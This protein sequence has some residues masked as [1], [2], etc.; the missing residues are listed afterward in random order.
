MGVVESGRLTRRWRLS[1]SGVSDTGVTE[2]DPLDGRGNAAALSPGYEEWR[3]IVDSLASQVVLLDDTGKIV[4]VN[5]AWRRSGRGAGGGSDCVG[6]NYIDVCEASGEPPAL[7][8]AAGLKQLASGESDR[9][10]LVYPCRRP[11]GLEWVLMRAVPYSG[12]HRGWIVITHQ[13][14][15]EARLDHQRVLSQG[16]ALDQLDAA[17]HTTDLARK[18]LTWNAAAERLYGWTADEALGRLTDEL[19][20]SPVD[21]DPEIRSAISSGRWHGELLLGRKDGSSFPAL[22]RTSISDSDDEPGSITCVVIDISERVQYQ[23]ELK[24]ARDHL[25]AVTDS[26]GEGMFTLDLDG[27]VTYINPAAE[28]MLGWPVEVLQGRSIQDFV[29]SRHAGWTSVVVDASSAAR[30]RR[31]DD[32][33]IRIEDDSFNRADGTTLPVAYTAAPVAT[34]HR[35]DGTVV[36]FQDIS[37]RKALSQ[38]LEREL[39]SLRW[40]RRIQ[41]ALADDDLVLYA[42]PIIDLGSGEVVQRELLIRMSD[43]DDPGSVISPGA[44]LPVA[45]EHGLIGQIDRWVIDRSADLAASG[46]AVELN[47]SAASIEDP[48][49]LPYIEGAIERSGADPQKM[50]FEITETTLVANE[51]AGRRFVERLQEIGSKV[52]LDDFGTGYGGFTYLKQLP[53]DYLKIDIEFVQDLASNDASRSVIEAIVTLAERFGLKTV[54]EGVED[55]TTLQL[56][57]DLGVNYAQGYWIGRPA[58]IPD[59]VAGQLGVS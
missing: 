16:A 9:F 47:I 51:A 2:P 1:T 57:R 43:P 29:G 46:L 48:E 35:T 23:R 20:L 36:L 32:G 7:E 26:I 38:R 59:H 5:E 37:E 39:A 34:G 10:E 44:F 27:R 14:V 58:P 21:V 31:D 22:V 41:G 8:A 25:R 55:Q 42:Q 30:D 56:L 12:A 45:E 11:E 17:V 3:Q 33:V 24:A 19:M 28:R 6:S 49:L 18:V 50:V 53:V 4:A 13:D 54:A 40:V 15:T 52:A